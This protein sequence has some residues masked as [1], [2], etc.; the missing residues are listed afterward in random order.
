MTDNALR[1]SVDQFRAHCLE[2]IDHVRIT[3]EPIVVT[4]LGS[5]VA[6]LQPCGAPRWQPDRGGDEDPWVPCWDPEAVE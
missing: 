3:G 1:V 2:L 6:R 5:P 4:R